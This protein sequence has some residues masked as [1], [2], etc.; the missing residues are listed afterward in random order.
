MS[1][2]EELSENKTT[3]E[4]SGKRQRPQPGFMSMRWLRLH[5]KEIIWTVI[6]TFLISL[7]FI[8]Y[9]TSKQNASREEKQKAFEAQEAA[10]DMARNALPESIQGKENQPAVMVCYQTNNGSYTSP[11][12]VKTL[13]RAIKDNPEY[14]KL[15]QMPPAFR[16]YYITYMKENAIDSLV[17]LNLLNLYADANGINPNATV[18]DIIARAQSQLSAS[19]LNRELRRSGMTIQE[20]GEDQLQRLKAQT[21]MSNSLVVIPPASATEDFMKN[22]YETHKAS[23]KKDDTISFDHLLVSAD[24]FTSDANVTDEQINAYY[25][26]NKSTLLSSKRAEVSHIFIKHTDKGYIDTMVVSETELKQTYNDS[27]ARFTVP[28]EVKASHILIK[29]RGEGDEEAKFAEAK[30]VIDALYERAKNGED[31][32][33][34][35]T[36]NSEDEGSAKN[37]GDLGFFSHGMMVEQFDQAAFAAEVGSITEPVRTRFG[38]HVIKVVDKK[39]ESVKTFEEV[40]EQ[41]LSEAKAKTA[42]TKAST[43]M[44]T[45]RS[46]IM[47]GQKT[48]AVAARTNPFGYGASKKND[49]KLPVFFKGE[50]TD[51]YSAEDKATLKEEIGDGYDY[52]ASEIEEQIFAMN[53]GDVSEVI[54][55][56]NGYHLFKLENMLE[57]VSLK[58]TDTLKNKIKGILA[59]Q[60]AEESAAKEAEKLVKENAKA[61]IEAMVKA[62]G[63]S[64]KN[65]D[66]NTFENLPFSDNPGMTN[67]ELGKGMGIFSDNGRIYV[68][69]FHKNVL[70]A[71]KANQLNTYLAPFKSTLGW[72]IV[73]VTSYKANQYETYEESKDTIRRVVTLEP[74]EEEIKSNYEANKAQYD[75]PATRTIRQILCENE[76]RA[77]KA[78]SELQEGAGF[79]MIARSYSIDSSAQNGGLMYAAKKGQYTAALDE[80]VWQ[81]K[82]GEYTKP[83]STPYGWVIAMLEDETE[84]IKGSL[85]ATTTSRIKQNLREQNRNEAVNFILKGLLNSAQIVRNQELIDLIK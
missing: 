52:V 53:P 66:K 29:P 3:R 9:G 61:N 47:N 26:A 20:Y 22:Y 85:D 59:D 74:S 31:F 18:N 76:E 13:W 79:S 12:D 43:D 7:F 15:Q 19:E 77:Q 57:P 42:D 41:L 65:K 14:E 63:K 44:E 6:I 21:A 69:E 32:A 67:A 2:P 75:T 55:T 37:G 50:I 81:L 48:F 27:K 39:A 8:G 4:H 56:N 58:L 78:Y 30:K 36:D 49:G 40:K 33:K 62:Y 80:A 35:A 84:E 1:N 73:K 51:D 11:I 38:Y 16:D 46:E 68:P 71:V 64:N 28:E 5:I 24:D 82:K 10:E 25:E 70:A 72:H 17:S 45:L 34:L 83:I 54:K 23:F 60:A